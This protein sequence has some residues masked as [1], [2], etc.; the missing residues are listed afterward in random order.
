L[1]N[2]ISERHIQIL[3]VICEIRQFYLHFQ[4]LRGVLH[5]SLTEDLSLVGL[6]CG[7]FFVCFWVVYFRVRSSYF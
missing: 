6:R 1:C 3:I 7:V 2:L 4:F 5:P